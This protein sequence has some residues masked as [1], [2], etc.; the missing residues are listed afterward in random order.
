MP[1]DWQID[2]FSDTKTRPSPE[3]R[4]AMADAVCGDEQQDEDSTV[5]R[6]NTRVAELVGKER[7]LFL[8][9]GTMANL[10]SILVHCRRGDE[11]IV[12]RSA[13][14]VNLETGGAASIAGATLLTIEGTGGIFSPRLCEDAIRSPRRNAPKPSL[15][16]IEQTTNLGGGLVWPIETLRQMREIAERHDMRLHIDGARLLNAAASNDVASS[17]YGAIAD[18]L[19]IDFTKGLGAPFG[20]VL[21]GSDEFIEQA[22]RFKHMLG[23]AMRQAG[24]MAAACL[25]SL[26]QGLAPLRDDHAK[27]QQ[28]AKGL[29]AIPG[30][31]IHHAV[32]TNIIVAKVEGT[33]MDAASIQSALQ[34]HG[35]RGGV[36]GTGTM[37]FITHRDVSMRDIERFVEIMAAVVD[38]QGSG[39]PA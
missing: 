5:A 14:L 27:A 29:L 33:G 15:L 24:V 13:H 32:E 7:G 34:S 35:V 18:T 25:V 37:R 6:L 16:W 31:E 10:I 8:P 23:G 19:W 3:M 22:R 17:A 30:I 20:A 28:L 36:F 12:D 2:L 1:A 39:G 4:R 38:K 21:A 26:D 11:I 9:S